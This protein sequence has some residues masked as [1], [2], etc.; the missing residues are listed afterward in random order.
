M[1]L[2]SSKKDKKIIKLNFLIVLGIFSFIINDVSRNILKFNFL[3]Q[4]NIPFLII[5][6]IFILRSIIN[7]KYDFRIFILVNVLALLMLIHVMSVNTPID[8]ILYAILIF[9][10]FVL[11]LYLL[12]IK[13]TF[14]E[15]LD[16]LSKFLNVYNVFCIILLFIGL[17]DYLTNSS[18]QLFLAKNIFSRTQTGLQIRDYILTE[19]QGGIYRYYSLVGY[20]LTNA[21]FFLIFFCLNIIYSKYRNPK[22][23][24]GVVVFI[25]LLGLVISGSKTALIL[26]LLLI[27]F[28]NKVK[29]NKWLYYFLFAVI[30]VFILNTPIFQ[31]NLGQR[32][33]QGMESGD[34]TS[35]RNVL[36][37]AWLN[38]PNVEMPKFL[39]G[40]GANYS[41]EIASSL[42]TGIY[43]FEYPILMLSYDYGILTT[44]LI[45]W[46]ILIY[47]IYTFLKSRQ[48]TLLFSFLTIV[49]MVN[50]NNGIATIATDYM[51]Q[52]CLIT[53][54]YLNLGINR[55]QEAF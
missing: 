39:I 3:I 9:S 52:F 30:I 16:S 38:T 27:L 4:V 15:I 50:S 18:I 43:N 51:A 32:Y 47:P 37:E 8:K 45:Y 20:P 22:I 5:S 19:Y 7:R 55:V 23:N 13:Y 26:G 28:L 53:F 54:I 42:N 46:L 33:I 11:P 6:I 21:K 48:F 34:I 41:R 36:L 29:R 25:T 17:L 35:G 1:E 49:L 14:Q 31:A 10:T 2:S 24:Q 44:V 40:K 12:C